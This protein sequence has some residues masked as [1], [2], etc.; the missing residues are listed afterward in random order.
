MPF[1]EER[2]TTLEE[3]LAQTL[4]T[5]E[6]TSRELR[7]YQE[8]A[9]QEMQAFR[10][11][12]RHSAEQTSLA[13]R[14]EMR[15]SAEQTSLEL[16]EYKETA[17]QE[18][19]AFKAEMR[20]F[21]KQNSLELREY[22]ETSRQE[23]QAFREE[24]RQSAKQNS[25]EL[26]EYKETSRQE[27]Q[28]FREEM[29]QSIE[30]TSRELLEY[31]ETAHQEMHTFKEEMRQ[32][33]ERL[34]TDRRDMK[35]E[36]NRQWGEFS[37]IIGRMAED[38]VA[39]SVPRI[40]RTFIDCPENQVDFRAVQVKKHIKGRDAEFDVVAVCGD[41]VLIN[42]TKNKLRSEDIKTFA[43][44]VLPSARD[45]F[46]EYAQKKFIGA[47][48]S[49]YVDERQVRDGEKRGLIVLGFGE[50]VMEVLNSPHFIPKIF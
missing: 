33:G 5:V 40:L 24:M 4:R 12:M 17:H 13:F 1:I 44:E 30:Q 42:E 7:E 19:Q 22:K 35:K 6:Q 34:E 46:P 32:L 16:H 45:F 21:A 8:T 18:M 10:E 28:A 2:V 29:R 26:R 25:L 20:Q 11:E 31:K 36:M 43:E 47:I 48:A 39:P 50:D 37:R 49:L 27:T 9:H 15:Q 3:I 14:E 23:M 38:L 41:Y